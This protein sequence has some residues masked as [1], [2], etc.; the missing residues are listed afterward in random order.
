MAGAT[1]R[2]YT[3]E[4][5]KRIFAKGERIYKSKF[6][7]EFAPKIANGALSILSKDVKTITPRTGNMRT[8][9]LIAFYIRGQLVYAKS[10]E[11]FLNKPPTRVTLIRGEAYDLSH[12]WC[13]LPVG[14]KPYVGPT[15]WEHYF[16]WVRS[17]NYAKRRIRIK[18]PRKNRLVVSII[19]T[20]K[21]LRYYPDEA[22][23]LTYV[24]N[25]LRG[26][27]YN[28][29]PMGQSNNQEYIPF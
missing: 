17:H 29:V 13:G 3:V 12:Y 27:R 16:S 9:W 26:S 14:D 25:W 2:V 5:I 19:N 23:K 24:I 10:V 22:R 15:G 4:Q 11:E 8:G 7:R 6:L 18:N 21:Y 20:T 28:F 1:N